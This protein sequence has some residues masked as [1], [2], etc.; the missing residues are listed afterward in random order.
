MTYQTNADQD[1]TSNAEAAE[2]LNKPAIFN[3]FV[4]PHV[5]RS[6]GEL[7]SP[8]G[9]PV[10]LCYEDLDWKNLADSLQSNV[11]AL[12]LPKGIKVYV[13]DDALDLFD[14]YSTSAVTGA[15]VRDYNPLENAIRCFSDLKTSHYRAGTVKIPEGLHLNSG[16]GGQRP[17]VTALFIC[18]RFANWYQV[19]DY[20]PMVTEAVLGISDSRHAGHSKDGVLGDAEHPEAIADWLREKVGVVYGHLSTIVKLSITT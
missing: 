13:G 15:K 12:G 11:D 4:G 7:L 8:D 3:Y 19:A 10:M 17:P 2:K 9:Q 16:K 5:P 1:E 18:I 20:L 6:V 14:I